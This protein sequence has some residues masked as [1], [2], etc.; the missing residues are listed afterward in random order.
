MNRDCGSGAANWIYPDS[1]ELRLKITVP[2]HISSIR[3]YPPG[4]HL[5]ELERA[6][7]DAMLVKGVSVR[8]MSAFGL[9]NLIRINVG[10]DEENGRF[11]E[12]LAECLN[13]LH[14]V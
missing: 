4:K 5:E 6:L 2:P 9:R 8:S 7:Y 10:T 14:Y 13:E 11:L 12:S 1:Q 3:P